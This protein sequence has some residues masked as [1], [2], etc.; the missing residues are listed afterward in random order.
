MIEVNMPKLGATMEE[1]EIAQWL[2]EPGAKVNEGEPMLEV[3][4]EKLNGTI[5][6]PGTGTVQELKFSVG[7]KVKCGEVVALIRK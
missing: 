4:T 6:A 5:E 7:D 1:G 2:V 3:V